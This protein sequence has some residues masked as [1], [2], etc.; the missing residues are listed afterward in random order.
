AALDVRT[1]Q[2]VGKTSARH[3]SAAFVAFLAD[4]VA[5][6]SANKEI[7][8]IVDNLSAHK[9]KRV[10]AF[11]AEHPN[12]TV[13]YTPRICGPSQRRRKATKDISMRKAVNDCET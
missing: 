4:V 7:H 6:Q 9:T 8:I 2:V 5:T 10:V 11:L 1:G 3:T 12:V 13:H